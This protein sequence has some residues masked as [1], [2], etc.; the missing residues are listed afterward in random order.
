MCVSLSNS[1]HNANIKKYTDIY[2]VTST[3][4]L[5]LK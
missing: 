5:V 2:T 4:Y 1:L 3:V